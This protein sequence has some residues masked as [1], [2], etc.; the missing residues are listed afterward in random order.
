MFFKKSAE[1][2][3]KMIWEIRKNGKTSHLV[4]TAHFFPYSFNRS[5]R[6]YLENAR[7]VLFE[8]PLDDAN[9]AK[10]VQAGIEDRQ[11]THLFDE[12]G[13]AAVN[14]ITRALM[15][16]CRDPN[17]FFIMNLHTLEL[18]NPVYDMIKGM[19]PWLA[20][21]SIWHQYLQKNG[22]KYSVDLEAYTIA[23]ELS[24][25]IV[26]METIEEQIRV[27]EGLA[28]ER[29]I[30]FLKNVDHWSDLSR[31]YVRGYL[32][33]DLARLQSLRLRFPSRHHSVINHRDA[34]FYDRMQAYLNRGNAVVCVGAPHVPG[35]SE[36]LLKEG[37]RIY[38]PEIPK[39]HGSPRSAGR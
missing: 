5:F 16:A 15:P 35:M 32:S 23:K 38:G 10:V 25:E 4:G 11:S 13:K 19:K 18:E 26:F 17:S 7:T 30:E 33:G 28:H 31:E 39:R 34:V 37:Y 36:L 27:L 6:K 3:L 12:L 2:E 24:K 8:G 22:W 14:R 20:F 1:K 29:I 21:F 9:M